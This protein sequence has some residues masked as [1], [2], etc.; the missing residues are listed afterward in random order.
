MDW[1]LQGLWSAHGVM[2]LGWIMFIAREVQ[3]GL[4]D[5]AEREWRDTIMKTLLDALEKSTAAH[6][7]AATLIKHRGKGGGA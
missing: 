1:L 5:K 4:K 3:R 2:A 7:E 6:V